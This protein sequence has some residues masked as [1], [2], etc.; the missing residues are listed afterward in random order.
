VTHNLGEGL[1]LAT[2]AAIMRRGRLVR[3]EPRAELE[4]ASYAA[5]YRELAL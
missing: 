1:A 2:H 3:H 5:A 4:P